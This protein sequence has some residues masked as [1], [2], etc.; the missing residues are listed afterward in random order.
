M[1]APAE[2]PKAVVQLEQEG[3]SRRKACELLLVHRS[4]LYYLP[5]HNPKREALRNRMRALAMSH[6]RY[7]YRRIRVLLERDGIKVTE[8][9][10][11]RLWKQEKLAVKPQK[12][13][14][15]RRKG[16]G[17]DFPVKALYPNH[18]WTYDFMLDQ[19]ACGRKVR[20][21]NILDEFTRQ[22]YKIEVKRS[23]TAKDVQACLQEVIACQG[24]PRFIR[25]DNGPEFIE[26][27]L[28]AWLSAQETQT[29][30]IPPGSPW[31]NGHCESFNGKFR[32]EFLNRETFDSLAQV[33]IQAEWWRQ[34][35]NSER[36]HS[37]LN[38][39]TPEAFRKLY[40][41]QSHPETLRAAKSGER[42]GQSPL[43]RP[44]R[45]LAG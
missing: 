20:F 5:H 22:C 39:Q 1:V 26:K 41:E 31:L 7:G 16:Q 45:F 10:I 38:Y 19:L 35:Y 36:P 24:A 6:P 29:L 34:H 43:S 11:Q 12:R 28:Q 25:S 44:K 4:R 37:A 17:A 2:K 14:R 27:N 30:Y 8:K 21:L 32:D 23:L 15:K 18:V 42:S 40:D 13:K 3:L 33:Q 9:R